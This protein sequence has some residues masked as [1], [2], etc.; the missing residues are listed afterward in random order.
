MELCTI[1]R[2]SEIGMAFLY[3]LQFLQLLL[4]LYG[5]SSILGDI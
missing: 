4:F 1:S 5:L 2:D 3:L